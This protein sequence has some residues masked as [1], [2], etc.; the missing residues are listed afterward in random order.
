MSPARRCVSEV[1][2][3]EAGREFARLL[4]SGDIVLLSGT[5]GA[6]KTTFVQG[7]AQGLGVRERVTSP[8]FTVVRE[9]QCHNNLGIVTLHHCDVYRVQSLDEV[10]DLALGELVEEAGVALVEWGDLAATIFGPHV[11][12]VNFAVDDDDVRVLDVDGAIEPER[13]AV[14][15]EW[16]AT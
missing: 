12:R 4:R 3:R 13:L 5:L 9:H 14:L 7:V 15:V 6:G 8:T 10:L 11:V 16:S 1:D 2:T